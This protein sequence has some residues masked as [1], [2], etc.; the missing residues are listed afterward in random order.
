MGEAMVVY[1]INPSQDKIAEIKEKL[2]SIGAKEIQEEE[3]GFGIV[4]LKTVFVLEDKPDCVGELEKK[5]EKIEG[6]NS[7]QVEGTSLI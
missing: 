1:R 3:I 2:S 4:S 5:I 7:V 6:I